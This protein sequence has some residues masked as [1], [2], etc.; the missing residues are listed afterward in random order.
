[1]LFRSEVL[2]MRH[3][4]NRPYEEIAILLEIQPEA[5]RQRYGRALIKLR[6]ILSE[7]GLLERRP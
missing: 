5:A 1:M 3:I 2:L 6:K 7:L 4:E